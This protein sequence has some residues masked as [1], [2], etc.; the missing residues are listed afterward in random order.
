M[1][2]TSCCNFRVAVNIGFRDA[3]R[4]QESRLD[5]S[6]QQEPN[7]VAPKRGQE[8]GQVSEASVEWGGVVQ[9]VASKLGHAQ[10]EPSSPMVAVKVETGLEVTPAKIVLADGRKRRLL[11]KT[12]VD[13]VK[14]EFWAPIKC[15]PGVQSVKEEK[16]E[17]PA[18]VKPEDVKD[19]MIE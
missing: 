8:S 18:D 19:E 1:L 15:E 16:E 13:E 10:Q 5:A 14:H 6:S 7:Y 3:K 4:D 17:C 12:S 9:V 11:R 2:D